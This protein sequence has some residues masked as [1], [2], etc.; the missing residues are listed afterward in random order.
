MLVDALFDFN[1]IV[2]IDRDLNIA[3]KDTIL[4][5]LSPEELAVAIS[6]QCLTNS[7]LI[8]VTFGHCIRQ[9]ELQIS[10]VKAVR[11]EMHLTRICKI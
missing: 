4:F 6:F 8:Q 5:R 2:S 11:N 10:L 9:S 7:A 3:L 1:R